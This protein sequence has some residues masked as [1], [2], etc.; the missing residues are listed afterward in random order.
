M[1][2]LKWVNTNISKQS[3]ESYM[4]TRKCAKSV[5]LQTRMYLGH[6][7]CYLSAHNHVC[8]AKFLVQHIMF[9]FEKKAVVWVWLKLGVIAVISLTKNGR[10]FRICIFMCVDIVFGIDK[11]GGHSRTRPFYTT[12]WLPKALLTRWILGATGTLAVFW[13]TAIC[14]Q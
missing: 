5:H 9:W 4:C 8:M 3:Y 2:P 10:L 12:V 11:F 6:H 13:Q 14:T 7:G 1:A